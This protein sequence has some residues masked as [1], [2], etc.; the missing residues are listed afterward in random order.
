MGLTK[1]KLAA[2]SEPLA[3]FGALLMAGNAQTNPT[4]WSLSVQDLLSAQFLNLASASYS[5]TAALVAGLAQFV[6]TIGFPWVAVG[7]PTTYPPAG[8]YSNYSVPVAVDL[9]KVTGWS[10]S[11]SGINFTG[12]TAGTYT[13]P[14]TLGYAPW[15]S[16]AAANTALS[17]I[18]NS[19]TF[20][21]NGS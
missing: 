12:L 1:V 15:S 5:S 20:T 8:H 14:P 16:Y 2:G 18:L 10:D 4:A 11:G 3:N 21:F 6:A 9:S 19:G 17:L 13:L 7:D